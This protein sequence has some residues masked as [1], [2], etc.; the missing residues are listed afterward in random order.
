MIGDIENYIT[1][2]YPNVTFGQLQDTPDNI[3]NMNIFD[4]GNEIVE[5]LFL[6]NSIFN[7]SFI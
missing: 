4:N 6:S 7:N 1:S 2:I 3:V 5:F